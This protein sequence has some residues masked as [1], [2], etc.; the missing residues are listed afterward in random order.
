MRKID[1]VIIGGGTAGMAAAIRAKESDI[2]NILV[3]EQE[4]E[5]GGIL[6]QCIHNGFGLHLFQTEL[7]GPEFAQ[8][9]IDEMHRLEIPYLL[10][11]PVLEIAPE[12]K[13]IAL[14]RDEGLLEIEAK[15]IVFA[16]GCRERPRGA[17]NITGTRPGGIMTAGT[18][19]RYINLEGYSI[20]RKIVILGSGDIGLIMARRLTLEGAEVVCVVELMPFSNGLTRNVVQCLEDYNIPLYLSHTVTCV[21]GKNRVEGVYIARVDERRMPIPETERYIECDT[22]LLSVG[23]IPEAEMAESIGAQKG[24][25]GGIAV[26][27]LMGSTVKGVFACGNVV[28]VHDLVDFVAEEGYRA[29]EAA[30]QYVQGLLAEYH[31]VMHTTPGQGISYIVP[32]CADPAFHDKIEFFFR[33][34]QVFR[35]VRLAVFA[36]ERLVK[37]YKKKIMIPSE[38]EKIVLSRTDIGDAREL[39]LEVRDSHA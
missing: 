12:K 33:V 8:R 21:A 6:R 27:D 15:T 24:K 30:A 13:I 36:D 4:A 25:T 31:P 1:I 2:E 10:H 28:Q 18:A 20:G 5:L 22:L 3:L 37:E 16:M 34:N 14:S 35:E 23:L 38:M 7:T 32:Q 19:Q 9:F 39:R 26:N 11:T 29:G 17:I